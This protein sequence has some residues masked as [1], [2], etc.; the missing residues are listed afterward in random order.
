MSI[1]TFKIVV[2]SRIAQHKAEEAAKEEA[3][4]ARIQAEEE[5]KAQAKAKAEQDAIIAKAVEDGKKSISE[6]LLNAEVKTVQ[7]GIH[8][9]EASEE[10]LK[11]DVANGAGIVTIDSDAPT[12]ATVTPITKHAMPRA[13]IVGQIEVVETD[14]ENFKTSLGMLI[15]F[16]TPEQLR[17]ALHS[18]TVSFSFM[19]DE[20]AA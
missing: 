13:A 7:L 19:E 8:Q 15:V 20:A 6:A 12:S 11:R 2:T 5:A 10:R 4:R 14:S 3:T 16:D 17:A 18:G 9:S 1:E